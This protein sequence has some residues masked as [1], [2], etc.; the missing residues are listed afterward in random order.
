MHLPPDA[1]AAH[2]ALDV[3]DLGVA[4]DTCVTSDSEH[5]ED[6]G[7]KKP[8]RSS[9]SGGHRVHSKVKKAASLMW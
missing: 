8:Q 9:S 2:R 4:R 1:D 7:D 6:N 3:S 5:D